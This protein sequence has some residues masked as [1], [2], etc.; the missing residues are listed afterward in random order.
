MKAIIT[1]GAGFIGST[2]A[3]FLL[4]EGWEG[5]AVDNLSA[6]HREFFEHNLDNPKYRFLKLE[7]TDADATKAAFTGGYDIVFHFAANADVKGGTANPT[8]DLR[9]GCMV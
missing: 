4:A 6:G 5:L 2:L 3:D 7:L 1:G 8:V 9:E